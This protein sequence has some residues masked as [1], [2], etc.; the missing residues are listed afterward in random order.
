MISVFFNNHGDSLGIPGFPEFQ[1]PYKPPTFPWELIPYDSM[2]WFIREN[3]HRKSPMIFMG[4]SGW[5]PVSIFPRKP[6]H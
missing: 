4:K 1:K 6:I 3:F 5:F 2:D